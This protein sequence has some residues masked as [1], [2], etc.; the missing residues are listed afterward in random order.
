L[1]DGNGKGIWG[2]VAIAL[3]PTAL[4]G[5]VAI[6]ALRSDVRHIEQDLESK[7]NRETVETQ[8]R[9]ILQGLEDL[10]SDIRE[11]RRAMGHP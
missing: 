3:I 8:N 6:A 10:R 1:A 2:R 11:L 9:A 7:A 5:L 4:A